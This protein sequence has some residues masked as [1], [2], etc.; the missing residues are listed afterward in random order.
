MEMK[1][2]VL[3]I[4]NIK[5]MYLIMFTDLREN[6]ALKPKAK[7]TANQAFYYMNALFCLNILTKV[8]PALNSFKQEYHSIMFAI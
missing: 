3:R 7:Q 5:L 1:W 2:N 8:F 6:R 4:S